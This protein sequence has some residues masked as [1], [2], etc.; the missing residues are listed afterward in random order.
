MEA[1]NNPNTGVIFLYFP[2]LPYYCSMIYIFGGA[3]DPPHVGHMAI[4]KSI[5]A[6]KHPEKII[7]IPSSARNDKDY[8][9]ADEHRLAML[10]IFADEIHQISKTPLHPPFSGGQ[11]M[12]I[13]DDYFVK[14]WSGEMI[15]KDV[16]QY[17]REKY[18]EDIVHIFGTDTIESMPSWDSEGYAAKKVRKLFVPRSCH[19]DGGSVLRSSATAKGESDPENQQ[20]IPYNDWIASYLAMTKQY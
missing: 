7:I 9:V 14:N 3:F 17:C 15:T 19:R 1:A 4:V 20:G 12:V 18:G 2:E 16:D 8:S 11:E 10:G 13:I 6:K 5:L